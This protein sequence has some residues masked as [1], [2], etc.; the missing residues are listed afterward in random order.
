[1]PEYWP[2][3]GAAVCLV[4]SAALSVRD[5]IR[6]VRRDRETALEVTS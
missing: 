2:L 5:R 3:I 4:L 6:R 1:M